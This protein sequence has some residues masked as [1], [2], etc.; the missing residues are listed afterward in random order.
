MKDDNLPVRTFKTISQ[1]M[2]HLHQP[3]PVH[4]LIALVNYDDMALIPFEE[5]Q[6]IAVDFYKISF[7]TCFN[8]QVKYGQGHYDFEE[9]GL[10]FLSPR[11]MVTT[12]GD[13]RSYE[14]FSL[15]FHVDFI[16]NYPLQQTISQYGFFSYSVS[17]ALFLSAG[18]KQIISDLFKAIE[19]ELNNS[20]DPYSQDVLV[21][22]IALLLSYSNRFYNRQFI[23]RKVISNEI[24]ARLDDILENYFNDGIPLKKGLP[25]V[26]HISAQLNV[27]QRYLS[28]MLQSLTGCN[29][30]QYIHEKLIDKAKE[31][32]SVTLLS[33]SEIAYEL[34][35]EHP[36]SFNKLFKLKV[37]L[38]PSEYR[39]S[40][41]Y[42][43]P[44][45]A[46]G[47]GT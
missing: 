4:P 28:D 31:K 44:F 20:A 16:R 41:I 37:K 39:A 38:S 42:K 29:T 3:A 19:A 12:S 45:P 27:S 10:A 32:L 2:H 6:K 5:E 14:G 1:L 21:S 18:E 40:F 22:Q 34:G 33:I 17:E 35:F 9:G 46:N 26:Q 15:F 24:L 8:G 13:E 30:Q 7:K 25:G 23:T 47:H 36:Q 43:A 11:Q